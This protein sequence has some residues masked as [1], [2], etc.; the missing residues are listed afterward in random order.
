MAPFA[1]SRKRKES[2]GAALEGRSRLICD[3]IRE[4]SPHVLAGRI[5]L[6]CAQY[7][8]GTAP[9]R[10]ARRCPFSLPLSFSWK[11]SVIAPREIKASVAGY[12]HADKR[13]M[14]LMVRALFAM[15]ETPEP[16]DAADA[17]AVALC[18][19][20]ADDLRRRFGRDSSRST[21]S[22]AGYRAFAWR[23]AGQLAAHLT[24]AMISRLKFSLRSPCCLVSGS[25]CVV[26][27]PQSAKLT[28]R[29]GS[30][31]PARRN[32]LK[33]PVP[34]G[35]R[36]RNLRNSTVGGRSRFFSFPGQRC[37]SGQNVCVRSGAASL[38]EALDL[39]VTGKIANLGEKTF[40]RWSKATRSSK[41]SS[42][43]L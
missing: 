39:D 38:P 23:N 21:A 35:F 17:L 1:V 31:P 3:L 42:T 15:N 43:T 7:E 13:Q 24:F 32:L 37:A 14:Q 10:S 40:F 6:H 12:G 28:F 25:A 30:F 4:Y 2:A 9:R 34:R 11:F 41:R 26:A 16:S 19:L 18:H 22:R 29:R 5:R 20:Q 33:L 8:N 36:R 27:A